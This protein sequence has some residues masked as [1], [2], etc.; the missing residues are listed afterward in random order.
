MEEVPGQ[1]VQR[2]VLL[3]AAWPGKNRHCPREL[4]SASSTVL[5]NCLSHCW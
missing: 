4:R 2:A 3:P 5:L 1:G